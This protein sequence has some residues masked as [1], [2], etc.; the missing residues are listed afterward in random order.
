MHREETLCLISVSGHP[1]VLRPAAYRIDGGTSYS[2]FAFIPLLHRKIRERP[3]GDFRLILL[4]PHS[5]LTISKESER[6]LARRDLDAATSSLRSSMR[7]VILSSLHEYARELE[8]E[9]GLSDLEE[10]LKSADLRVIQ[11]KGSFPLHGAGVVSFNGDP[12]HAFIEAHHALLEIFEERGADM[13]VMVDLSHGWNVYTTLTYLGALT[14]ANTFLE[15]SEVEVHASEPFT[16]ATKTLPTERQPGWRGESRFELS[17]LDVS[18]VTRVHSLASTLS[19]LVRLVY[20]QMSPRR[21]MDIITSLSEAGDPLSG[22]VAEL[23]FGMR[24]LSCALGTTMIPY[25]HRSLIQ[26]SELMKS[27]IVERYERLRS[28]L[29][30]GTLLKGDVF[31]EADGYRVVYRERPPLSLVILSSMLKAASLVGFEVPIRGVKARVDL[32]GPSMLSPCGKPSSYASIRLV[33]AL[34]EYYEL[35][36]MYPD[37][38]LLESELAPLSGERGIVSALRECLSSKQDRRER[39]GRMARMIV[40]FVEAL[41]HAG[42]AERILGRFVG[43][44][45]EPPPLYSLYALRT[46]I[47]DL[48]ARSGEEM[49]EAVERGC[50]GGGLNDWWENLC[51]AAILM[52]RLGG[53]IGREELRELLRNLM[54]HVGIQHYSVGMIH[55]DPGDPPSSMYLGYFSELFR[56]LDELGGKRVLP[57]MTDEER[58]LLLRLLG[59]SAVEDLVGCLCDI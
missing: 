48:V 11:S 25:I 5:L 23:L 15:G 47:G 45:E 39:C 7:E 14:F 18:D 31:K 27:G 33:D 41:S 13:S 58:S 3:G 2:R 59:E 1:A 42:D 49:W 12:K 50:S 43:G 52:D 40:G 9:E 54:A 19:S 51:R 24:R 28:R 55:F 57:T 16:P 22:E 30:G 38:V 17:L 8:G 21:V 53:D 36:G 46:D 10:A 44:C 26:L 37:A 29:R 32:V 56:R 35:S 6:S 4:L 20:R 34:R